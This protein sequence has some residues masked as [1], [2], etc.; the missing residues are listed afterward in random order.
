LTRKKSALVEGLS[1]GLERADVR[2][3]AAGIGEGLVRVSE[4]WLPRG[5]LA[6]PQSCPVPNCGAGTYGSLI[7]LRN[8]LSAAHAGMADRERSF[9]LD[10]V[11]RTAVRQAMNGTPRAP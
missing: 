7:A 10:E 9:I 8:H 11:R 6:V 1:A 3:M 5:K 4:A 2:G